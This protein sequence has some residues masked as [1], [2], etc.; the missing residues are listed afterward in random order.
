MVRHI[1][2]WDLKDDLT[3]EQ[4]KAAAE[5]IKHDLE[6]LKGV[7]EGLIDIKVQSE[8]LDTSN[9]DILLDSCFENEAA[10]S[11]YAD[12]PEHVKVKGFGGRVTKRRKCVDFEI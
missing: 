1:I 8:L 2:I 12:H 5:K 11:Y 4:K 7:I 3:N 10:L 6:A 9:G